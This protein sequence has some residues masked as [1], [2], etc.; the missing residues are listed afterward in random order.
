MSGSVRELVSRKPPLSALVEGVVNVRLVLEQQSNHASVTLLCCFL[1]SAPLKAA[2]EGEALHIGIVLKKC[3]ANV[4]MTLASRHGQWG[5][6]LVT[7]IICICA[8]PAQGL[9]DRGV[10][11]A[12]CYQEGRGA[13]LAQSVYVGLGV[14]EKFANVRVP[15]VAS[16]M[17]GR[18]AVGALGINVSAFLDDQLENRDAA[19][20]CGFLQ[21]GGALW[22]PKLHAH[23][24]GKQNPHA[25]GISPFA[26]LMQ[27][28][29]DQVEVFNEGLLQG[30]QLLLIQTPHVKLRGPPKLRPR[31][32]QCTAD[33]P[34]RL[35]LFEHD[36]QF[37]H[38]R[39]QAGR[40]RI[41]TA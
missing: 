21:K 34:Q 33:F 6:A 31:G 41:D 4:G 16:F 22:I 2:V 15:E 9:A 25:L 10:T 11:F 7:P 28:D 14:Q 19:A 38:V 5:P 3:R 13:I 26:K 1:Q 30:V 18:V 24:L 12:R 40:W 35:I 17:Q 32:G 23:A 39:H 29:E 8:M 20:V 27:V 36:A 37:R